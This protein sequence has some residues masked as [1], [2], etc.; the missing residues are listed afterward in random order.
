MA[1]PENA[2]IMKEHESLWIFLCIL[3]QLVQGKDSECISSNKC[4]CYKSNEF[5]YQCPPGKFKIVLHVIPRQYVKIDCYDLPEYDLSIFP[6]VDVGDL[7]YFQMRFCPL[8][9]NSFN[10]TLDKFNISNIKYMQLE[11]IRTTTIKTVTKELFNGLS[12]LEKLSFSLFRIELEDDFLEN[13]PN[14]IQLYLDNNEIHQLENNMF[15]YTPRLRILHL[16]RNLI[17][18]QLH[19]W[20]NELTS[21]SKYSFTGLRQLKSLE[22]SSNKI[23]S[24]DE[25]TF[26]EL[27]ELVNISLR[28]NNLNVITSNIFKRNIA[29]EGVRIG[30]NPNLN[31]SD[32]VFANLTNLTNVNIDNSNLESLPQHIFEGSFNILDISI[33]NNSIKELPE[34]IFKN[35]EKLKKLNLNGNKISSLPNAIFSSLRS[36]EEL[37]IGD[38]NLT[39]INE[40]LFKNTANLRILNLRY[41]NIATIHLNAFI[42]LRKLL[43]LDLS[44]NQYDLKYGDNVEGLNPFSY[45]EELQRLNL[46]HNAIDMFPESF[47]DNKVNLRYFD[48]DYNKINDL[49]VASLI[50]VST[51]EVIVYLNNNN[52]SVLD[53]RDIK[54]YPIFNPNNYDALHN[55]DSSTVL[56]MSQN[57]ISCDCFNF[58]L[59]QYVNDKLDPVIKTLVDIRLGN[60]HCSTPEAFDQ[61]LV[62]DLKP[63]HIT[64]PLEN[65]GCPKQCGCDFRPYDNCAVVDCSYRNLTNAPVINMTINNVKQVE[66]N[67]EGNELEN[68]PYTGLG[69]DNV[70]NL[71]LSNNHIKKLSWIPPKIKVLRLDRN[72]LTFIES[73]VL[74]SLN[75]S[76]TLQ[77]LTLY[78]NPWSCGCSTVGLQN[79]LRNHYKK[80]NPNEVKCED[81][82]LLIDRKELCKSHWTIA[83]AIATPIL[84]VVCATAIAVALYF[85]Y[86]EEIKVWLYAKNLCLWFVT[87][88]E[89]DKDKTYDI[90][91]SY[92]HKDEEFVIQ[93]LL[94]VLEAGPN[95]FKICIHVRDWVPGEFIATQVTN[96]VLDSRRTL[97]ILSES[98]LESVWGKMEFRTAHTQAINEGRARVIVVKYGQLNEEKLDNE[99]KN[100]P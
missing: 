18:H 74:N 10:P 61:I 99:L 11:E 66:V 8:P 70:T 68:A 43:T 26:A 98:F 39:E 82:K 42:G 57:P 87:E 40:K 25:D 49:R 23:N 72:Q 36:L 96:S 90:F 15:Y 3:I 38:N 81:D 37:Y 65:M 95:P 21:L 85:Y 83:L 75:E 16:S 76:T 33:K 22:L 6:D 27:I 55:N 20:R 30:N 19:L 1:A 58:D 60:L 13:L 54:I 89:L 92:S 32:Y 86:Q 48:L 69:Y 63:R 73:K 93:N 14:L 52:I 53:F 100:V 84:L 31:L 9:N 59:I 47:M 35:L 24:L 29:L 78:Q 12:K 34:N 94:P 17:S 28:S 44:Y 56:Y 5:E 46:S 62:R 79:Y 2:C 64:C 7:E 97:V 91:I 4:S 45:C 51:Y 67:L 77:N 80:V 41:N 71:F 88:E 50:K